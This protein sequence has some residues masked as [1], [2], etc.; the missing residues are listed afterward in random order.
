MRNDPGREGR[1]PP[2]VSDGGRVLED[3]WRRGGWGDAVRGENVPEGRG[4]DP[5]R[6]MPGESKGSRVRGY[7]SGRSTM[8]NLA[9]KCTQETVYRSYVDAGDLWRYC[10]SSKEVVGE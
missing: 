4:I 9:S 1:P 8:R 5:G 6:V 10:C 7:G 3:P 2:R